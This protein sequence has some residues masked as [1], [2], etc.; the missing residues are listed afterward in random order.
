MKKW[1][2]KLPLLVALTL[3]WKL[4][5]E[6]YPQIEYFTVKITDRQ[7]YANEFHVDRVLSQVPY[8]DERMSRYVVTISVPHDGPWY[9]QVMGT[10]GV[11][12]DTPWSNE[13]TSI[14]SDL[15]QKPVLE[16]E[17]R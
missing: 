7:Q 5:F 11:N 12:Y 3:S 15:P 6:Q 14:A 17:I 9:W 2:S 4:L 10:N 8:D 16:Y 1:R 13:V